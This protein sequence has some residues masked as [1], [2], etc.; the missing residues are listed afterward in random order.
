MLKIVIVMLVSCVNSEYCNARARD[1]G[2]RVVTR[3]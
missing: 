1:H 3:T 2:D